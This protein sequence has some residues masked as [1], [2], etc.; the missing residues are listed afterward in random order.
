MHRDDLWKNLNADE[1]PALGAVYQGAARSKLFKVKKFIVKEGAVFPIEVSF[2]KE[3]TV[4]EEG[5]EAEKVEKVMRRTLFQRSNPFPSK[6]VLT[7]SRN[8]DDF[9]FDVF[10]G[11]LDFLSPEEKSAVGATNISQVRL[12]GVK[13]AFAEHAGAES[14]GIKVHFRMDESGL[15]TLDN[16]ESRFEYPGDQ[17]EE[18]TLSKIGSK[19]SSFFG[20]SS[21]GD[22][23]KDAE[24]D[25]GDSPQTPEEQAPPSGEQTPP[26]EEQAP[27]PEEP[28]QDT[29]S[30][31]QP[32]SKGTG[33]QEEEGGDKADS[34][35]SS[36][37][38][39]EEA[40]PANETQQQDATG[41]AKQA[42]AVNKTGSKD[43]VL[44][45]VAKVELKVVVNVLDLPPPSESTSQASIAKLKALQARDDERNAN[46]QAKNSLEAFILDTQAAMKTE[47]FKAVSNK[48]QREVIAE[49]LARESVW[50]EEEGYVAETEAFTDKLR[51]LKRISK[52]LLKRVAEADKRP[53]LVVA[54]K[55]SI[56]LAKDFVVK[57]IN[58]TADMHI[59]TEVELTTLSTLI[60]ETEQWLE[61]KTAQQKVLS[62][63]ED[64]VLLSSDLEDYRK[65]LEREVMYLINKLKT[66]PPPKPKSGANA[67][68]SSKPPPKTDKEPGPQQS[69][70]PPPKSEPEPPTEEAKQPPKKQRRPATPEPPKDGEDK[71]E[72]TLALPDGT[73]KPGQDEL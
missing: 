66:H 29:P 17:A 6:K 57:A 64:P 46:A 56:K 50:L 41:N 34:D 69:E 72:E 45:K 26:P 43:K 51:D 60:E 3:D 12:S 52:P 23:V 49:A 20:G 24:E 59:F 44:G 33:S 63:H 71:E 55:E 62:P 22:E 8:S 27:P 58:L 21:T 36:E 11:S 9:A 1:A 40:K 54:I 31:E 19:I 35:G 16:V 10:Y 32:E 70:T 15:L 38:S 2:V 53:K 42:D 65:R 4:S 39:E 37:R 30:D 18:S 7:F 73:D 13:E 14:K 5:K 68:N 67:T 28:T 48:E 25:G 47:P 61:K